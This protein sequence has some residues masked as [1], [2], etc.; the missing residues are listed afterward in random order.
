[1]RILIVE[2]EET[3]ANHI[4]SFLKEEIECDDIDCAKSFMGTLVQLKSNMYD[5]I[6]L[7]MSL[8]LNDKFEQDDFLTFGGIEILDELKRTKRKEHVLVFTAFDI[9]GENEKRISLDKLHEKMSCKYNNNYIG[10]VHY[11]ALSLE[12]KDEIIKKI[13][14]ERIE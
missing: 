9:L 13:K 1:M 12:W 6:I 7:D 8:P 3:K 11:N 10:C 4:L 14:N 2:D 5:Y